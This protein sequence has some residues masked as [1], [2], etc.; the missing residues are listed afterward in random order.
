MPGPPMKSADLVILNVDD[1]PEALYT[2]DRMLRLKGFTVANATTERL[3]PSTG[4]AGR[5]RVRARVPR[6]SSTTLG[7]SSSSVPVSV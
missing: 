7:S 6:Y 5:Y 1:K 2:K 3:S 4:S